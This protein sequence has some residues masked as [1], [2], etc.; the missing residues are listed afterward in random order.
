[1]FNGEPNCGLPRCISLASSSNP[2]GPFTDPN[3]GP[4]ECQFEHITNGNGDG[5]SSLVNWTQLDSACVSG[6]WS[7]CNWISFANGWLA[8]ETQGELHCAQTPNCLYTGYTLVGSA[9]PSVST[10]DNNSYLAF[11]AD[12][13][14]P[15]PGTS[16]FALPLTRAGWP[17]SFGSKIF[18]AN[19]TFSSR[20]APNYLTIENPQLLSSNGSYNLFVSTGSYQDGSYSTVGASCGSNITI[21]TVC[22]E[23]PFSVD[24]SGNMASPSASNPNPVMATVQNG[25]VVGPGGASTFVDSNG[26]Y[27]FDY[28]AWSPTCVGYSMY[29]GG[30][31]CSTG[32]EFRIDHLS[33]WPSTNT[34]CVAEL[35]QSGLQCGIP[36]AN[37]LESI[38]NLVPGVSSL[39]NQSAPVT[40][41]TN[42]T[43]SGN[44]LT[45][46]YAVE[47]AL[48]TAPTS[49]AT[50]YSY[51]SVGGVIFPQSVS[52]TSLTITIPR[53]FNSFLTSYFSGSVNVIPINIAGSPQA[54]PGNSS[55]F[56]YV[57]I[58]D[59]VSEIPATST[60][61]EMTQISGYGF[62]DWNNLSGESTQLPISQVTFGST[63]VPAPS[64]SSAVNTT[65]GLE[66]FEVMSP[67]MSPPEA[68]S[69]QVDSVYGNSPINCQTQFVLGPTNTQN[70]AG[71]YVPLS[72]PVRILDTRTNSS[73]ECSG[74]TPQSGQT[75]VFPL[76]N[77]LNDGIPA[78]AE[79][80]VLNVTA[81]STT[82][83]GY[84][85][86]LDAGNNEPTLP[87]V[88]SLNYSPGIAI[89][90]QVDVG[91]N[92]TPDIAIY[93]SS[94]PVD[95]IVDVEG[96]F[97]STGLNGAFTVIS[98]PTRIYDSRTMGHQLLT[99]TKTPIPITT[100]SVL[101]PNGPPSNLVAIAINVTAV[102]E[103]SPG[104]L[105]I[106]NANS[107]N[108]QTSNVN[109]FTGV[110]IAGLEIVPVSSSSGTIEIY[111]SS[112]TDA[113]IDVEG[114]FVNPQPCVSTNGSFCIPPGIAI[115]SSPERIVGT[116]TSTVT[117]QGNSSL[118]VPMG[119][120][121]PSS[122][123]ILN[124]TVTN[125]LSSG[126][127]T[128][129]NSDNQLPLASNINWVANE[130]VANAAYVQVSSSNTI[131]IFNG[132]SNSV[133]VLVDLYG[134]FLI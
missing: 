98:S 55:S 15:L 87:G 99:G 18:E 66:S 88:S 104:Y 56:N 126:Y 94:G 132:S 78:S 4:F 115:L 46:T 29:K 101:F 31:G 128:V 34:P 17:G 16:I 50:S 8:S 117:I 75:T 41:G 91:L 76:E 9:D 53:A 79:G 74:D 125:G 131:T 102:D 95:I 61:P 110:P 123:A 85:T 52:D 44:N 119:S 19:L 24:S 89:S 26:G 71:Y 3:Q 38:S 63:V 130:T 7:G 40:G 134:E 92:N 42:L 33:N 22:N 5:S 2:N 73:F 77:V 28:A 113:L 129:Y 103:V 27:W 100:N 124:V 32:R 116:L 39:S 70:S 72:N 45:G 96:Y 23:Y 108:P 127:L 35:I 14:I 106:W 57:P 68:V 80:V 11:K 84:L 65:N 107:Q 82:T 81:I 111:T 47:L 62:L 97:S 120:V 67:G 114:Y 86:V 58:V 21:S 48:Q 90:N 25:S 105:T 122:V 54:F 37:T 60:Q 20:Y 69:V 109:Y 83:S 13:D 10:G 59:K 36:T 6:D 49:N 1:M 51:L 133:D 43:V 112:T 30:F 121:G 12:Y 118:T 93:A 64:L